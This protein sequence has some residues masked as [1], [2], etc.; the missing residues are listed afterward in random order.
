MVE[1]TRGP[2]PLSQISFSQIEGANVENYVFMDDIDGRPIE[3]YDTSVVS[4]VSTKPHPMPYSSLCITLPTLKKLEAPHPP[5]TI[6]KE[7]EQGLTALLG[8]E[9]TVFSNCSVTFNINANTKKD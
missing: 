2:E 4:F 1:Y 9:Q 3:L 8:T 6:L 5:P 7:S